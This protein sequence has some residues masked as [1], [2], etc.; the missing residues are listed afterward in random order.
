MW[1]EWPGISSAVLI[2]LGGVRGMRKLSILDI[3]GNEGEFG[4]ESPL[5]TRIRRTF[6][7]TK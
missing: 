6:A 4:R 5:W 3:V 2:S 1:P 7:F